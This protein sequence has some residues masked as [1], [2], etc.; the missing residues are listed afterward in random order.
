LRQ[1]KACTRSAE[2]DSNRKFCLDPHRTILMRNLRSE[3]I[4][5]VLR[6]K[7]NQYRICLDRAC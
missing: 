1:R 6:Q 2:Q 4:T 3:Q 5:G 7:A